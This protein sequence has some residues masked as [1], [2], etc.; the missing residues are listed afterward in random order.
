M[1]AA[2]F[3]ID[4]SALARI[5]KEPTRSRWEKPLVEGLIAR[6]P[7]AE[8]EFLYTARNA[9]DREELIEDLEALFGWTPLDDRAVTRAWSVQQALTAK[10]L[11]RSA[12]AVDLL[13]AATAELQG[14]TVL[15][16]D[17]DFE[18]IASVAGQPTQWLMP[19]GSL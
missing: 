9:E 10:G 19:P 18:T 13:I 8:I 6:C 3:L 14:L 2:V 15:H 16:Y 11:H 4:T 5:L 12:G 7:T 1:N 17:N